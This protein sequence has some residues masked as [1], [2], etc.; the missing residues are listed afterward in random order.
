M[1]DEST[2]KAIEHHEPSAESLQAM[3]EITPDRFRRRTGRGHH[4][5]RS[6]GEIV[7]IDA[8]DHLAR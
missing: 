3:P 6:V 2:N 5:H 7:T 8:P 1:S 4:R